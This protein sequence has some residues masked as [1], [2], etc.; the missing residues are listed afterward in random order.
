MKLV[1]EHINEKFTEDSDPIKDMEIGLFDKLKKDYK[2]EYN[3]TTP[4]DSDITYDLLLIFCLGRDYDLS[5]IEWLIEA[6]ADPNST[7]ALYF[8]VQRNKYVKERVELLLKRGAD[9]KAYR[10]KAFLWAVYTGN[11]DAAQLLLDAGVNISVNGGSALTQLMGT[12]NFPKH[13]STIEWLIE[14]GIKTTGRNY[15]ALRK[16][17]QQKEY[18]LADIFTKDYLKERKLSVK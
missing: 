16:A 8:A 14:K 12:Y 13:K 18:E 17:L 9:P 11:L 7:N 2:N 4:D 1:R 6:G 10:C 3:W 5:I 15:Y